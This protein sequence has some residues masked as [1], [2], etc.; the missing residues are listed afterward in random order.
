M[1]KRATRVLHLLLLMFP[2]PPS[3]SLLSGRPAMRASRRKDLPTTPT[4]RIA[5]TPNKA[6]LADI[7]DSTTDPPLVMRTRPWPDS[8]VSGRLEEC[9]Y[10]DRSQYATSFSSHGDHLGG[11]SEFDFTDRAQVDL[12]STLG[13]YGPDDGV[14]P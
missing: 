4:P 1:A 2:N 5:A 10:F 7:P 11:P 14:F 3:Y 6:S 8:K 12:D 13:L 9:I